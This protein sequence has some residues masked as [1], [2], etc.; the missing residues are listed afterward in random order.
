MSLYS[1][2]LLFKDW[3]PEPTTGLIHGHGGSPVANQESCADATESCFPSHGH[4]RVPYSW[5]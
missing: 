1:F 2:R 4:E 5:L 3:R